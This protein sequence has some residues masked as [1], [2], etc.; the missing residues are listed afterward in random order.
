MPLRTGRSPKTVGSNIKRLMHEYEDSG[1]IGTSH[2]AS[3]KKAVKQ[4]VAI[5][6]MKAGISRKQ[7]PISK[8]THK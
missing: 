1:H 2:P 8:S 6:L 4:A 7:Q 5:A 3:K